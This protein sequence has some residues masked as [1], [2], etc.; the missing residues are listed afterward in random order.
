LAFSF[1]VVATVCL[2]LDLDRPRRGVI[3]MNTSEQKIVELRNLFK[4]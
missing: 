3:D 2:I 4:E 1:T